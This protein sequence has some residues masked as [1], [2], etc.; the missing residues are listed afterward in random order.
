[1]A[2]VPGPGPGEGVRV[3]GS[4]GTGASGGL[5]SLGFRVYGL[6]G[7]GFTKFRVYQV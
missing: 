1:M 5:S 4:A 3:R 6:E 2:G 7:L